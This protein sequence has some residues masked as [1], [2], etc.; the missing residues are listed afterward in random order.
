[1]N[2]LRAC[3][4]LFALGLGGWLFGTS[5]DGEAKKDGEK[6]TEE[7]PAE[8]PAAEPKKDEPAAGEKPAA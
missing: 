4:G 1:M 2:L 7:K 6:K 5:F 3:V 8:K